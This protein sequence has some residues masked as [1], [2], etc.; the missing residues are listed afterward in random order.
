[1]YLWGKFRLIEG[2]VHKCHPA[3]TG[4]LINGKR[5]VSHTQTRV[6]TLLDIVPWSTKAKDE[7]I[8]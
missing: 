4:A 8:P 2:L 3:I 7:K 5:R 1:M 6:A